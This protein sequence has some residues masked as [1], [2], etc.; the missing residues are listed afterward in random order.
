MHGWHVCIILFIT[1]QII[2]HIFNFVVN[3]LSLYLYSILH[4]VN[5]FSQNSTLYITIGDKKNIAE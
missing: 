2:L 1:I 4:I 5:D 3:D